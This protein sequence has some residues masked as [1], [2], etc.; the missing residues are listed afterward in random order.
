ML[1]KEDIE[2]QVERTMNRHINESSFHAYRNVDKAS[3]MDKGDFLAKL[4]AHEGL[5]K[6]NCMFSLT[7]YQETVL[8]DLLIEDE[9]LADENSN[10]LLIAANVAFSDAKQIEQGDLRAYTIAGSVVI[11]ERDGDEW[12][13]VRVIPLETATILG[14]ARAKARLEEIEETV[15]C[16]VEEPEPE[17]DPEVP[18]F[19]GHVSDGSAASAIKSGQLQDHSIAMDI[20]LTDCEDDAIDAVRTIFAGQTK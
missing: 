16:D 2:E 4:K 20:D 1:S 8:E 13:K 19:S 18:T 12:S 14:H 3:D 11:Q 5:K 9:T 15:M 7:D 6:L 17:T 10:H